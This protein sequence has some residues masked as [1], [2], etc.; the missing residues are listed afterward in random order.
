MVGQKARQPQNPVML[1]EK[2][3]LFHFRAY[4]TLGNSVNQNVLIVTRTQR[5]NVQPRG[6]PT[7]HELT[8]ATL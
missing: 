3:L 4:F 6:M 5:G 7:P 2:R 1:M 8:G